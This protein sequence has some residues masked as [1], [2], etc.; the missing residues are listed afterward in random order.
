MDVEKMQRSLRL[1]CRY[2]R[3]FLWKIKLQP[4]A[5]YRLESR[6]SHQDDNARPH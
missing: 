2:T 6:S 1:W 5:S 4:V 3:I